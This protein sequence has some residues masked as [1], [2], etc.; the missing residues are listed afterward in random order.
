MLWLE[1]HP[2]ERRKKGMNIFMKY[3]LWLNARASATQ[4]VTTPKVSKDRRPTVLALA[5]S[6]TTHIHTLLLYSYRRPSVFVCGDCSQF[7]WRNVKFQDI[8]KLYTQ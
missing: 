6:T 7:G 2:D 3:E 5:H 4:N 8:C 1:R